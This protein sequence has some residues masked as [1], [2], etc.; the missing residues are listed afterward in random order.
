M[1]ELTVFARSTTNELCR[2]IDRHFNL[3]SSGHRDRRCYME[4]NGLLKA[5]SSN[6]SDKEDEQSHSGCQTNL[7]EHCA[8]VVPRR[9]CHNNFVFGHRNGNNSFGHSSNNAP[10]C[11]FIYISLASSTCIRVQNKTV[12]SQKR[13][14]SGEQM[15]F[16]NTK[17][18]PHALCLCTQ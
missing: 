8:V 2:L 16:C 17:C 13:R 4:V 9:R 7:A 5:N 18:E 6:V 14:W 11:L 15:A 1:E 12:M 3:G 10:S